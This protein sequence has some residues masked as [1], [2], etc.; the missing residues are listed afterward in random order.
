ME[1]A[2]LVDV[3]IN[4][5]LLNEEV[6][7]PVVAICRVTLDAEALKAINSTP[8]GLTASI[9]TGDRA[10]F[11]DSLRSLSV[12]TVFANRCDYLRTAREAEPVF[13]SRHA[14]SSAYPS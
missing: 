3:P 2:I 14:A 5:V 13:L 8:Y 12:G 4:G 11:E 1:P 10:F 9:W 6:F 7:G